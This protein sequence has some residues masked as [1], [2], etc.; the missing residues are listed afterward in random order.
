VKHQNITYLQQDASGLQEYRYG[1]MGEL[2]YNRHTYVLP[3]SL[4]PFS[5]FTEW[6]YDSWNRIKTIVYP[7]NET[8]N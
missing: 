1:N 7:D 6:T 4:E 3:N 5:L 2:I 8:V